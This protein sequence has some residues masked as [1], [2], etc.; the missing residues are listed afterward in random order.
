MRRPRVE[1]LTLLIVAVVAAAACNPGDDATEDAPT[2]TVFGGYRGIEAQRFAAA[3]AP[4][5]E[6]TGIT[7]RYVGAGSF[8][9]AMEERVADADYPDI[10]IFPQPGLVRQYAHQGILVPLDEATRAA[11][12]HSM[13]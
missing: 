12:A 6:R 11:I 8:A 1:A 5:E 10:G 9:K 2:V 4:F 13:S 7:V 3:M